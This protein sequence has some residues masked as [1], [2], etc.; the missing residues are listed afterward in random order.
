M[1]FDHK[2]LLNGHKSLLNENALKG[3]HPDTTR[4]DVPQRYVPGSLFYMFVDDG[5]R[6]DRDDRVDRGLLISCL[7]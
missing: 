7:C 3:A 5:A 6:A 4:C 2:L 1:I